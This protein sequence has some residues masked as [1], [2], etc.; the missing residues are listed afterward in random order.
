MEQPN[1]PT[2]TLQ[3]SNKI[4]FYTLFLPPFTW[5]HYF[6]FPLLSQKGFLN[7]YNLSGLRVYRERTLRSDLLFGCV[8]IVPPL[9]VLI[10]IGPVREL[11]SAVLTR[12]RLTTRVL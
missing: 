2:H 4:F 12:I 9:G 1:K 8:H 3:Y 6:T 10:K 11:H 5:Y 7:A